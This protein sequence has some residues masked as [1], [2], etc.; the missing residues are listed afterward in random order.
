MWIKFGSNYSQKI[1]TVELFLV[2]AKRTKIKC[3][4]LKFNIQLL[5]KLLKND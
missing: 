2:Q 3:F 1:F 4:L 5:K